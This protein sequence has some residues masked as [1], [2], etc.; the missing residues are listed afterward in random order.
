M[1]PN[2]YNVERNAASVLADEMK[3]QQ[4]RHLAQQARAGSKPRGERSNLRS[5]LVG[6][7]R[8]RSAATQRPR[9]AT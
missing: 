5:R 3:A 2:M 7:L 4:R 9:A 1:F 6:L 8:G